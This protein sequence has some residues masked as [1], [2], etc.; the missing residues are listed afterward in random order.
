MFSINKQCVRALIDPGSTHS[1]ISVP[2]LEGLG[3]SSELL[4]YEVEVSNPLGQSVRVNSIYRNCP[5]AVGGL[6]FTADLL[7]MPFRE[8]DVI[9]G[10]DWLHRHDVKL[11]CRLKEVTLRQPDG[12]EVVMYGI[13]NSLRN[14]ISFMEAKKLVRKGCEA[15]LIYA[16]EKK[17]EPRVEDIETVRDFPDVFPEKLPGLP[18]E[19]EVEFAIDLIPGSTPISIAP[20]RMAPVELKELK[21][22]LQELLEMGFIR[23]SVSP[24][25]A[26]V[27]F[28]KK[29]M[30]P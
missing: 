1:Y 4:D 26:P 7:K 16:M 15:Y 14:H 6:I 3:L 21:K 28:V 25:G 13:S 19:R 18:P 22:Q 5:L 10:M 2:N 9:L 29:K 8:F 20:Y 24:W 23:P 17:E 11:E 12:K 30:A 27:L